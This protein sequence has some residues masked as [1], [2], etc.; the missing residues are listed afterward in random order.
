VHRKEIV[1]IYRR[2]VVTI[3]LGKAMWKIAPAASVH[4]L[5]LPALL[6]KIDLGIARGFPARL[7]KVTQCC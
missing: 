6:A 1:A 4:E 7:G 3:F 2:I 5:A